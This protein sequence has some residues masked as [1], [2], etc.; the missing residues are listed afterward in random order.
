MSSEKER[1]DTLNKLDMG[2]SLDSDVHKEK[3]IEEIILD[4]DEFLKASNGLFNR[5]DY[6]LAKT[7]LELAY[8][9]SDNPP[10][11]LINKLIT[12]NINVEQ[13]IINTR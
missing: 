9:L 4:D 13:Y 2:Y 7:D 1:W 8:A 6:M 12:A 10:E 3:T 11:S 5:T